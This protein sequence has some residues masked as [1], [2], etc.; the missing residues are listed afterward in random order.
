M[1]RRVNSLTGRQIVGRTAGDFSGLLIPYFRPGGN[2]IREYRIRRDCPDMEFE[3]G[4][5]REKA[6]YVSPPGRG[7]LLYYP[8][9]A[10]VDLLTRTEIP[11]AITE[12]E[13]K[14]LALWPLATFGQDDARFLPLGLA[15]VWNWC[16]TICKA[17]GPNG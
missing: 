2:S 13:F 12:G 3:A 7:N 14:T 9:M 10:P 17:A 6:K 11:I 5:V 15:G 1:L 8:P 16:G 4:K